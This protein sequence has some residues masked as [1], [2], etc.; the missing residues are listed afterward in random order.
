MVVSRLNDP[1]FVSRRHH[2]IAAL[3]GLLRSFPI[4]AALKEQ[5]VQATLNLLNSDLDYHR[6]MAIRALVD[7]KGAAAIDAILPLL[8][9]SSDD[10]RW[11]AASALGDIGNLETAAK[12]EAVLKKRAV[13]LTQEQIRKDDSFYGGYQAIQKLRGAPTDPKGL[14]PVDPVPIPFLNP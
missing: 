5:A 7:L 2:L 13:G 11:A 4:S 12:I 9:H 10:T 6:G 3:P 1:S 8:E 14:R